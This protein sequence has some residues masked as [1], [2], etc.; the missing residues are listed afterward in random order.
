MNNGFF[1]PEPVIK[2]ENISLRY[3]VP[4]E[5]IRSF[6]EF[7]IKRIQGEIQMEEFWA[8]KNFSLEI[9]KGET[10]GIIGENGSG[11]STLLKLISRVLLPTS[12]R[13][14]V[15]GRIAPLLS[16]TA[17]FHPEL[18][19]RENIFLMGTLLGHKQ[20]QLK[21]N[22]DRIVEFSELQNFIDAP[23]RT[24]SSGMVARLG[25]AVASDTRPDILI[26]D[27]VLAVGD[28]A[29]QRK[30]FDRIASYREMGTTTLFV[31]HNSRKVQEL[32][33]RAVWI[34][35]GELYKIGDSAE[36]VEEYLRVI[37]DKKRPGRR[38]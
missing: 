19:G 9:D 20:K 32:C 27:E 22:F 1:D 21:E 17:G 38:L 6:K 5:K 10:F 36:I 25:F 16:V 29:F 4:H 26:V 31:S 34:V 30:C 13:V 23:V 24:Y 11:K 15:K 14:W 28:E 8:L 12:G 37:G 18:T 33:K 2:I 3:Y 35:K 7:A